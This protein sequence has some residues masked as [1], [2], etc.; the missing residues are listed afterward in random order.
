MIEQQSI[1]VIHV[2]KHRNIFIK[3]HADLSVIN[4]I[5]IMHNFKLLVACASLTKFT[6]DI[7]DFK[8][9]GKFVRAE[10]QGFILAN[11]FVTSS[12]PRFRV[13]P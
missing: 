2:C 1:I 4:V 12:C 7:M 11:P 5:C 13:L 9:L 10:T 8:C 3:E 6:T